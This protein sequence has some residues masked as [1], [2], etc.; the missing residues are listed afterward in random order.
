MVGEGFVEA[1]D[2]KISDKLLLSSG[3]CVTIEEIQIEQLSEPETTYN[4]EVDDFHT[5]YV[6]ESNVLVHNMCAIEV[7]TGTS[8]NVEIYDTFDEAFT[9]AKD[10]AGVTDDQLVSITQA[11]DKLGRF[12][13]GKHYN[14]QRLN[15]SGKRIEVS[16]LHH[17]A[18]HPHLDMSPHL[19]VLS[20]KGS[21][22]YHLF[23]KRL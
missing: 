7:R 14:Y 22:N 20:Q 1:K 12:M 21:L 11:R 23:Y 9:R 3:K 13:K 19:N 17:S 4:F 2:L 6:T 8:K 15:R 18:G 10:L 16:I 5:Y